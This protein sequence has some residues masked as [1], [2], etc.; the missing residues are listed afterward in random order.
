MRRARESQ[1]FLFSIMTIKAS[2]RIH[3][4]SGRPKRFVSCS[5]QITRKEAERANCMADPASG[6]NLSGLFFHKAVMFCARH[7]PSFPLEFTKTVHSENIPLLHVIYP[8][9]TIP[10]RKAAT[11]LSLQNY[12]AWFWRRSAITCGCS[13]AIKCP[14]PAATCAITLRQPN[15]LV[16]SLAF[17][18]GEPAP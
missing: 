12:Y 4:S 5:L 14:Q 9:H 18:P 13:L 1:E 3:Q 6:S 11:S 2:E 10:D 15:F 7:A 8:G 16:S 17:G